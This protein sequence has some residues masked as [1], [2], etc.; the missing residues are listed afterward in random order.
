MSDDEPVIFIHLH[1]SKPHQRKDVR[2]WK[3]LKKSS[4]ELFNVNVEVIYISFINIK[5]FLFQA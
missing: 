3:F 1:G 2:M 5:H 4:F